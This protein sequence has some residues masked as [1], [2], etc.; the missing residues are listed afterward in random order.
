MEVYINCP[1]CNTKLIGYKDHT[2]SCFNDKCFYRRLSYSTH[3]N[4]IVWDEVLIKDYCIGRYFTS[5]YSVIY[6]KNQSIKSFDYI[7]D[8]PQQLPTKKQLDVLRIFQ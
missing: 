4:E 1:L 5:N 8:Y 3:R 7:L 6:V 2:L